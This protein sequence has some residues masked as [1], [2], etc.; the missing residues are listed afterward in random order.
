MPDIRHE[1]LIGAP[2]EKIYNAITH[3]EGLAAWWTP[4]ATAQPELNTI[5][6]FPFG[7]DYHKEMKVTELKPGKL[8]KWTC[9][10]GAEEWVG[11]H[12]SFELKSG[13]KDSMKDSDSELSDQL[14]Q[15]KDQK[16]TLLSFH[17]DDWKGHTP[18]FAECN[19]TWALF[20]RSLK[21]LCETGKGRPWP[22]QHRVE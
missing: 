6:R 22:N 20:L 3:Q 17:H 13:D 10:A 18:M 2:A 7:P 5:A 9:I 19:Y 14:S 11:T 4:A 1:L 15:Q 21:L 8:L 16:I 12:I